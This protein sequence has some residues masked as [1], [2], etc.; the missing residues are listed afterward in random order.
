AGSGRDRPGRFHRD[1]QIVRCISHLAVLCLGSLSAKH[2]W[3][4]R[5]LLLKGELHHRPGQGMRPRRCGSRRG[6]ASKRC[7]IKAVAITGATRLISGTLNSAA[8]MTPPRNT[9]RPK[10]LRA[11]LAA[12]VSSRLSATTSKYSRPRRYPLRERKRNRF[13]PGIKRYTG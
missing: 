11:A 8:I 3:D 4:T 5:S 1:A 7:T 13:I 6:N 9:R 12:A 10:R 2:G